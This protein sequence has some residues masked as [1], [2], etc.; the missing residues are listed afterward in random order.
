MGLYTRWKLD[1]RS[2]CTSW[3]VCLARVVVYYM[4]V[5]PGLGPC[6]TVVGVSW[7]SS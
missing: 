5:V 3:P 6:G 4:Y 2:S 7:L 1:T